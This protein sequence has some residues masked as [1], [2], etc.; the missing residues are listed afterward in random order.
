[1]TSRA[2]AG[3]VE[4][5]GILAQRVAPH[6]DAADV[7]VAVLALRSMRFGRLVERHLQTLL[8]PAGLERSEL[9]VL[10]SLLLADADRGQTP[11]ELA[12]TVVQT[13]SGMTKTVNRLA[14]RGLVRRREAPDDARRVDILLTEAGRAEAEALLASLV[15]GFGHEVV[16]NDPSAGRALS[17]A[18]SSA[19][20]AVLPGLERAQGV[21]PVERPVSGDA[22]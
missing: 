18:L 3:E 22:G 19:L 13:T 6:V 11:T 21:T 9:S 7:D 4:V 12:R 10:M 15:A 8:G 1:M 16:A 17:S 20:A 2:A 5:P 14:A